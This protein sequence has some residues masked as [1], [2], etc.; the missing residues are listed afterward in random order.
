[1]GEADG[2]GQQ[3]DVTSAR[4]E[5]GK[6][7]QPQ[8]ATAPD[9]TSAAATAD[10]GDEEPCRSPAFP[11]VTEEY[12]VGLEESV[13][14]DDNESPQQ[15][16]IAENLGRREEDRELITTLAKS[17]FKGPGQDFFEAELAAYGYPVMMAWTRTGEI[18]KKAAEKGR[19]LS[20]PDTGI[21]WSRDDRC[22][23]SSETVA[24]ALVVFREKVLIAGAWDHTRGATI[25]TYFIGACLFQ[26]PTSIS[27]GKPS[28]AAGT[29]ALG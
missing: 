29:P 10:T 15:R 22:E 24:R 12:V 4:I 14:E 19:P 28:A 3:P 16:A 26:F 7:G 23:L 6:K 1:M 27:S 18:I 17:G 20:V 8:I 11:L 2:A 13:C 21:G 25:K 9:G 5:P